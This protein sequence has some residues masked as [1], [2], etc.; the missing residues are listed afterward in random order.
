MREAV[1]FV[2]AISTFGDYVRRPA[3]PL[4]GLCKGFEDLSNPLKKTRKRHGKAGRKIRHL[5]AEQRWPELPE[6]IKAAIKALIET[7]TKARQ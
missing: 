5:H 4:P 6:H 2:V 3:Y 7:G 1:R